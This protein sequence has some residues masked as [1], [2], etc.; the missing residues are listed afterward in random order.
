MTL[1][2]STQIRAPKIKVSPPPWV[3]IIFWLISIAVLA[4]LSQLPSENAIL[5]YAVFGI[6]GLVLIG[7]IRNQLKG[8]FLVTLQ[9]NQDG[10]YF[11]TSDTDKYFYVPWSNVGLIENAVFPLNS[12][13]IRI[14][15]TGELAD[16]IKNSTEIGN[17]RTENGCTYVYTIPQLRNREKVI[18]Q[19]NAFN[20]VGHND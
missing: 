10:L 4:A 5:K 11:Q 15:I 16:T 6:Y 3:W 9:A 18:E 13:G 20:T 8:N 19:L 12:R 17:V 14:E 7:V 2:T 1:T